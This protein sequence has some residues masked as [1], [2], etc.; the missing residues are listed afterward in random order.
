MNCDMPAP[1]PIDPLNQYRRGEG[2]APTGR[3]SHKIQGADGCL[4]F[5]GGPPRAD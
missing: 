3:N 4:Y 1:G 2:A 5:V